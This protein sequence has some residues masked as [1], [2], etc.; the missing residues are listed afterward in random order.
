MHTMYATMFFSSCFFRCK[1][2]NRT[3]F[4][5]FLKQFSSHTNVHFKFKVKWT[6][7]FTC[8]CII[9][10]F[11]FCFFVFVLLRGILESPLVPRSQFSDYLQDL[12]RAYTGEHLMVKYYQCCL[13]TESL[14]SACLAFRVKFN[15]LFSHTFIVFHYLKVHDVWRNCYVSMYCP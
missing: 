14:P 4:V 2:K 12:R 13:N 10:V 3:G 7:Q 8:T 1:A 6:S 11:L 15:H 5:A 9:W